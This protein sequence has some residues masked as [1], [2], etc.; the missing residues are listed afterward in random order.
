VSRLVFYDLAGIR[1]GE[2]HAICDRG[3]VIAGNSQ[4]YS[5]GSTTVTLTEDQAANEWLQFGR[6]VVVEHEKLPAWVGIL[7]TP[8][9]AVTPIQMTLYNA[10]Y[11]LSL[12]APDAA[13]KLDGDLGGLIAQML[14]LAN[15][16]DDLGLRPGDADPDPQ[17]EITL[18]Q[19]QIWD[20]MV[21]AVTMT[22]QELSIRPDDEN[23]KLTLYV[24]PLLRTGVDPSFLFH[25]GGTNANM[26]IIDATVD[27]TIRNRV[28]GTSTLKNGTG[29]LTTEPL[30]DEDSLIYRLRSA[31][32]QFQGI[33]ELSA[34]ESI[35]RTYLNAVSKPK[36]KLQVRIEDKGEAFDKIGLGNTAIFHA[37]Q[38]RLPGG[39]RGWKGVGRMLAISYAEKANAA[40]LTVEGD[41]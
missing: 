20:Q 15:A 34:L 29:R 14:Q 6:V 3:W 27:G 26:Q 8:W 7:D 16:Q 25:S 28:I 40:G 22:G 19:R 31:V 9:K 13:F 36:I 2:I 37:P 38:L 1:R 23:G 17:R 5:G 10:E 39:I 4:V 18:D 33:G 32:V 35:T 30:I 12:R 11:L 21:D 41:L 24:D